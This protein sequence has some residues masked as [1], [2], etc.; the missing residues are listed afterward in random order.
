MSTPQ[1]INQVNLNSNSNGQYFNNFF[2][3]IP[4]V[5]SN[6]NDAIV[7]YFTD[8]TDGNTAAA[9]ALA[10]AIIAT[11]IS[12]GI[13]PMQ[14]LQQFTSLPKGELNLFLV[15]FLNLN[16]VG[17]SYLG[18]SNAPVVNKYVQRAILA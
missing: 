9:Q 4:T 18:V 14:V 5:S 17:T 13:D 8:Q 10:S 3:N 6:Q 1:N 2:I 16:R 12:Q 11:S 7:G 15:T